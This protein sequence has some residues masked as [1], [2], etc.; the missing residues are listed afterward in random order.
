MVGGVRARAQDVCRSG[1]V[2]SVVEWD[3]GELDNG[4]LEVGLDSMLTR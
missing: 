1:G 2:E 4:G 3:E